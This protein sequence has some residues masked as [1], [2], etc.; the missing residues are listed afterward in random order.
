MKYRFAALLLCLLS[1]PAWAANSSKVASVYSVMRSG[2]AIGEIQETLT[3]TPGHYRLESSTIAVGVLAVFVKETIT[4]TSSGLC[5]ETGFH[6]QQ[7]TYQRSNKPQ[8]NLDA[9]FDWEKKTATFNF[10]GKTETQA[11]PEHLQDRLSL[12]HQFRYWPKAQNTLRLPVSNGKKITVYNLVRGGEE[13]ITVPA[14]SFL[15]TRYTRELSADDEG[16]SVWYSE[17]LAAP[18]KIIVEEKKGVLT[19]QVLLRVT[20]E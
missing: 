6:P 19:E 20:S 12:A 2:Q 7:Y 3:I 13:T 17:K 14:G 9:R 8:K 16:I 18:I 5:D 11:L 4:Q 15:S 1:L 10:D